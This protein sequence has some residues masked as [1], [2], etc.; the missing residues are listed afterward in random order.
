VI[1]ESRPITIHNLAFCV[2]CSDSWVQ[3]CTSPQNEVRLALLAAVALCIAIS[4]VLATVCAA[5]G[6]CG[7]GSIMLFRRSMKEFNLPGAR[8]EPSR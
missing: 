3:T 2:N 7:A 1:R 6:F 5:C 8:I 4:Y